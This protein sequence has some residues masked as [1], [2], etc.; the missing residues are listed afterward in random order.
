MA[1]P[2]SEAAAATAMDQAQ[3]A[4]AVNKAS[5][6]TLEAMQGGDATICPDDMGNVK[7]VAAPKQAGMKCAK[8]AGFKEWKTT[9]SQEEALEE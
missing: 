9:I 6:R 7:L 3:I 1:T 2:I 8:L 5:K 4:P